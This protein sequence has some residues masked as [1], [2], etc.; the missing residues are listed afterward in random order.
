RCSWSGSSWSANRPG[1][2]I[3]WSVANDPVTMTGTDAPAVRG[4][5]VSPT[6]RCYPRS[7]D[8]PRM[9]YGSAV[10]RAPRTALAVAS[11]LVQLAWLGSVRVRM[12]Y[13][14][15]VYAQTTRLLADGHPLVS[16]VFTSQPPLW[17]YLAL[18]GWL[19]GGVTGTR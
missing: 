10:T 6:G 17:P 4:D 7:S 13:D 8:P 19:G 11:L 2:V 5:L 16:D 18:P 12:R 9:P 15:G 14:E 1:K 3:R